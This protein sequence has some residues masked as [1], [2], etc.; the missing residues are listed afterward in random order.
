MARSFVK[1][2]KKS[3]SSVKIRLLSKCLLFKFSAS[4]LLTFFHF[5]SFL[6][7]TCPI[8]CLWQT[9]SLGRLLALGRLISHAC[10]YYIIQG[11]GVL[12]FI[13]LDTGCALQE[14]NNTCF[15]NVPSFFFFLNIPSTHHLQGWC[16]IMYNGLVYSTLVISHRELLKALNF[17]EPIRSCLDAVFF[18]FFFWIHLLLQ[19]RKHHWH[20]W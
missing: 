12:L 8:V 11:T 13:H 15:E 10:W 19:L 20:L 3:G 9:S 4:V 18:F 6:Y 14:I 1:K 17:Y 16:W 2:K 5:T 7:E